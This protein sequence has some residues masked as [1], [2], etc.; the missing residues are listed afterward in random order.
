MWFQDPRSL[1]PGQ[2]GS[3]PV[4]SLLDGPNV[5]P[6]PTVQQPEIDL[7]PLPGRYHHLPSSSSF[8]RNQ[9]FLPVLLSSH[10]S[11]VWSKDKM[12]SCS[13]WSLQGELSLHANIWEWCACTADYGRRPRYSG[14]FLVPIPRTPGPPIT[15][16]MGML[17]LEDYPQPQPEHTHKKNNRHRIWARG[18]YLSFCSG[19]MSAARLTVEWNP[20]KGTI[21]TDWLPQHTRVTES[22]HTSSLTSNIQKPQEDFRSTPAI[23]RL[24]VEGTDFLNPQS[25]E[26]DPPGLQLCLR[27]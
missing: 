25:Q 17:Q 5:R 10:V 11:L 22:S 15:D 19:G 23:H 12:S 20:L 26:E 21:E 18:T 24:S 16:Y 7:W 3:E 27:E 2:T 4:N 1:Y 9:S 14:S 8:S 13:L 6:G